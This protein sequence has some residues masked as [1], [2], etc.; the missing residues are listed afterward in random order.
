M[1]AVRAS[2]LSISEQVKIRNLY[3]SQSLSHQEIADQLGRSLDQVRSF[4]TRNH[5]PSLKKRKRDAIMARA[6][7]AVS[8][9]LDTISE[10]IADECEELALEGLKRARNAV[11]DT[12]KDAAKNFQAWT[13]GIRNVVTAR[14]LAKGIGKSDTL[15]EGDKGSVNLFFMTSGAARKEEKRVGNV[16]DEV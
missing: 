14:N 6:E 9:K 8:A 2:D 13:A 7:G 15:G 11:T 5:L 10:T 4:I 1:V 3:L 12:H 16:L